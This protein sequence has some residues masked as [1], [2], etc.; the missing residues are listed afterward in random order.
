MTSVNFWITV[1]FCI[2]GCSALISTALLVLQSYKT[3]KKR[4][5]TQNSA[6]STRKVNHT[7]FRQLFTGALCLLLLMVYGPNISNDQSSRC[8][9]N[10]RF[11]MYR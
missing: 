11:P 2:A 8:S 4:K 9:W 5:E 10:L 3:Y 1:T 6:P 7:K